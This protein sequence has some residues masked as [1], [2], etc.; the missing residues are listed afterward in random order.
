M[1][2]HDH[3]LSTLPDPRVRSVL[4]RLHAEADSQDRTLPLRFVDQIPSI[5]A[6]KGIGWSAVGHRLDDRFIAIDPDQG[7]FCYLLARSI[8]ARSIVEFGTS[9]GVSTIYLAL[10]VRENGGGRVVGTEIVPAKAERARRHLREAGLEE[11]VEIREGDAVETL[12]D[13]DDGVDM[14]LCDGFPPAMLPVLRIVAPRIRAGG[15][16]VSDNVG[17][18]WARHDEFLSWLRDPRNG[19]QSTMLALNGGTELSVKAAA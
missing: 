16:V 9:F 14:L 8:G 18:V 2:R 19:F 7:V 6:G 4:A 15:V 3:L 10:A 5:L 12:R 1:N 11:F 17:A 13:L